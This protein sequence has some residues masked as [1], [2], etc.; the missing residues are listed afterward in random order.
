MCR[1]RGPGPRYGEGMP[2]TTR[3]ARQLSTVTEWALV[4]ASLPDRIRELSPARLKA[5]IG[6]A[7]TLRDKYRDI[8]KRQHRK[9]QPRRTGRPNEAFSTRTARKVELFERVLARFE[10]QLDR[11][12]A[13]S[14][15]SASAAAA[16]RERAR[17]RKG[18]KTGG[19]K[20][21]ARASSGS[22]VPPKVKR[23]KNPAVP[24]SARA[25]RGGQQRIHAHVSSAGR[26]SQG[27]RD[28]RN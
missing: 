3:E 11:E 17:V 15:K 25:G 2:I 5:K 20:K 10:Q 19:R 16:T 1:G 12:N 22:P 28:G 24:K 6:R 9:A 4:E 27:R 14:A 8:A 18:G 23:S 13:T 7:R 21:S 26:R